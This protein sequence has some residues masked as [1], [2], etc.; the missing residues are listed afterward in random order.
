MAGGMLVIEF[1]AA[2]RGMSLLT[3]FELP[4]KGFKRV[5][6]PGFV[7]CEAG[8]L[9]RAGETSAVAS[10]TEVVGATDGTALVRL[11]IATSEAAGI[12]LGVSFVTCTTV[13]GR[14]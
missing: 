1:K 12:L 8:G 11:A 13:M 14:G 9:M 3:G 2:A 7:F 4:R 5:K 10:E 6:N